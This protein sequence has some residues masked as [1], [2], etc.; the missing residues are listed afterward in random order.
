M[1]DLGGFAITYT[2]QIQIIAVVILYSVIVVGL[3][4]YVKKKEESKQEGR[5]AH[6]LTGGNTVSVPYS[7]P[8]NMWP[9]SSPSC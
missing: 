1:I 7:Q 2:Q 3:G 8:M 4:L 6:F 9:G 5:L